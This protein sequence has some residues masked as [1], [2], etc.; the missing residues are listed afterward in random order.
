MRPGEL[1]GL[2]LEISL[3]TA[4]QPTTADAVRVGSDGLLIRRGPRGGLLLPQVP[5]EQGWDREQFLEG[6]CRKAGLPPRGLAGAGLPPVQLPGP[7]VLM[8]PSRREFLAAAAAAAAACLVCPLAPARAQSRLEMR[9]GL[10]GKKLSPFYEPLAD[11]KIRCTLCPH[12][13]LV[14]PGGGG[15]LRGAPQR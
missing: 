9:A 12:G 5:V 7:G 15:G 13:C 2:E 8:A 14:K 1:E 3:L 4:P 10:I 11:K 6:I